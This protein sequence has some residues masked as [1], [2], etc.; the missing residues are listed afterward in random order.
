VSHQSDILGTCI[1]GVCYV[2]HCTGTPYS[3]NTVSGTPYSQNTVSATPYIQ[4]TVSGTLTVRTLYLVHSQS[5]HCITVL[6]M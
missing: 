5:E 2:Y 6:G 3:Q 4:N 1:V